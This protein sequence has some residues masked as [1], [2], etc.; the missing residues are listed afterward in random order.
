M[1]TFNE[2]EVDSQP[3]QTAEK[4][5]FTMGR[6]QDFFGANAILAGCVRDDDGETKKISIFRPKINH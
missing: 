3:L 2:G 1:H 6:T 5:L 4:Y